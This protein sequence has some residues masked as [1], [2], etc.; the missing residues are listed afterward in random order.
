MRGSLNAALGDNNEPEKTD[1]PAAS[2]FA[3][4][5]EPAAA[6]TADAV[7]DHSAVAPPPTDAAPHDAAPPAPAAPTAAPSEPKP[8]K[9]GS[10][11]ALLG[12][13]EP[14]EAKPAPRG[15]TGWAPSFMS[16]TTEAAA[17]NETTL[18]ALAASTARPN[19]LVPDLPVSPPAPPAG[20][21][22]PSPTAP[23]APTDDEPDTGFKPEFGFDLDLPA[24]AAT[25][26]PSPAPAPPRMP[27]ARVSTAPF[28]DLPAPTAT[29]A[30][31]AT[32]RSDVASPR[33]AAP[34]SAADLR[35][36]LT[37]PAPAPQ[38][39][40]PRPVTPPAAAT[41]TPAPRHRAVDPN[42][43]WQSRALA[44]EGRVAALT[45]ELEQT[46]RKLIEHREREATYEAHRDEWREQLAVR[47]ATLRD[48]DVALRAYKERIDL[49]TEDL[50][51]RSRDLTELR[52]TRLGRKAAQTTIKQLTGEVADLRARLARADA[53]LMRVV[54][55]G[56]A[57]TTPESTQQKPAA[58][59][60]KAPL[61][62]IAAAPAAK[63][64]A[65]T[66]T[67]KAK[68][69]ASAA[70]TA[71]GRP[72]RTTP[73]KATRIPDG[74]AENG[75]GSAKNGRTNGTAATKKPVAAKTAKATKPKR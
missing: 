73:L 12:G 39:P 27:P 57:A 29:A 22:P 53:A 3:A 52:A 65:K 23:A 64:A 62:A 51:A 24:G 1:A 41:A 14:E 68:S 9:R 6:D 67:T 61:D 16:A 72:R 71:T 37:A 21:P 70:T 40:A 32:V 74:G 10:L 55:H 33:P 42:V 25:R 50:E 8:K 58:K 20:A 28:G 2:A 15:D 46:T 56:R 13:D 63:A 44:A 38:R 69:P 75:N 59:R 11:A 54:D 36:K 31:A 47:D 35:V 45:V 4:L 66:A 18:A 60:A 5:T 48:Q 34:P 43:E 17:Q 19:L 7:D 26:A 49:L 30:D